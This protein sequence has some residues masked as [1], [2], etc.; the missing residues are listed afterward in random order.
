MEAFSPIRQRVLFRKLYRRTIRYPVRRLVLRLKKLAGWLGIPVLQVYRGYGNQHQFFLMGRVIEDYGLDTPRHTDSFWRNMQSMLKRYLADGIPSVPVVA[1]YG[2]QISRTLTDEDGFFEF[3]F[4]TEPGEQEQMWQKVRVGL[5]FSAPQGSVNE[6]V[7]EVQVPTAP[8][9][10]VIS[11]V[12]DTFMISHSTHTGRKLRLML[13]KNAHTRVAFSGA[14]SFYHALHRQE[15]TPS[16]FFYVSS[17]EWNLYDLLDDF[18]RVHH[19]P[20]GTFLLRDPDEAF[21]QFWRSKHVNHDHKFLKI[22]A[23]METYAHLPFI[24]IGDSGQRDAEIYAQICREMP[25]RVLAVYIRNVSGKERAARIREMAEE[26]RTSGIELHL[27][28]NSLEAAL[29]AAQAG[30]ISE[31]ALRSIAAEAQRKNNRLHK[32]LR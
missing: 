9:F 5:A 29:H 19:I 4:R 32:L 8:R 7:G 12:D 10:G 2:G 13:L 6:A 25:S 30:F 24:L 20:K 21:W 17:S 18:C 11:D 31:E 26:L 28:R 1:E 27:V 3:T 16:P 23:I 14:P 22:R 15:G